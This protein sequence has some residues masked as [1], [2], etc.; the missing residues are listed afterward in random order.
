MPDLQIPRTYDDTALHIIPRNPYQLFVFWDIPFRVRESALKLILRVTPFRTVSTP[1]HS[2][3]VEL[4]LS[5]DST[6]RY[7][8]V[9]NPEQSYIIELGWVDRENGYHSLLSV[10]SKA[11]AAS[12]KNRSSDHPLLY[13]TADRD[14]IDPVTGRAASFDTT[15]KPDSGS[16]PLLNVRPGENFS[17]RLKPGSTY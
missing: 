1:A 9:D 17:S 12:R 13:R 3:A 10:R 6:G 7:C 15:R 16:T 8:A 2:P 14:T 11:A 5:S 4:E